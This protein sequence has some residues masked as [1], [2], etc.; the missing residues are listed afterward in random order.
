GHQQVR[1]HRARQRAGLEE[2]D[3]LGAVRRGRD[4]IAL[5]REQLVE[6]GAQVEV[7]F[8]DQDSV[9]LGHGVPDA[10]WCSDRARTA[11]VLHAARNRTECTA[12][13]LLPGIGNRLMRRD[14]L[15]LLA[16][17]DG[18]GRPSALA[19]AP[20]L[21][22]VLAIDVVTA[23][24]PPIDAVPIDVAIDAAGPPATLFDTGLCLDRACTT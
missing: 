15:A 4:V 5:T 16:I 22:D 10:K 1:D 24:T 14:F 9:R 18:C 19:D 7:I 23:D 2:L 6:R 3:A 12:Y 17:A 8:D 20:A 11:S 21:A 13:R